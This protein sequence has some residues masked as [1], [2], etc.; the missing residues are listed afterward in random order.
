M[1]LVLKLPLPLEF[2]D[3]AG[4]RRG[5]HAL[6]H[7]EGHAVGYQ[8]TK[9]LAVR[10]C[11]QRHRNTADGI[12]GELELA[13]LVGHAAERENVRLLAVDGVKRVDRFLTEGK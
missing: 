1:F 11:H 3:A 13:E 9:G 10:S 6:R 8:F 7:R 2:L 4:E 5:S 12:V